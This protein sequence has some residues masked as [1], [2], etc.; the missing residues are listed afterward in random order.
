MTPVAKRHSKRSR[1]RKPNL[2]NRIA[3][4]FEARIVEL[5]IEQPAWGQIRAANELA[6]E[7]R[8]ISPAGLRGV[9]LR[10]DLETRAKRLRALEA[11]VE[12][13]GNRDRQAP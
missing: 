10:H 12:H 7:G 5:A 4:D 9:W 13:S 6:K 2:R 3:P 11:K 8:P 1:A